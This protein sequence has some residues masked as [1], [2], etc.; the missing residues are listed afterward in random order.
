MNTNPVPLS[1]RM[2]AGYGAADFGMA[3]VEVML[4][5]FLLEFYTRA[6]GLQSSL[7][8]YALA[9]A[10]AWD[11][12]TDPLMGA[13]SDRTHTRWGMRRPYMAAGGILF[14]VS[15]PVLF[16][17]PALETQAGKFAYLLGAYLLLNTSYTI[18]SVPYTALAGEM[19]SDRNDRAELFGWRLL[20]RNGGF[21]I[22]ALLPG[23]L[24]DAA[25]PA[26]AAAALRDSRGAT[27]WIL[28]GAVLATAWI[29]T[30]AVRRHDTPVR[31]GRREGGAL[32]PRWFLH[33]ARRVLGNPLFLP[34]IIAFVIA[35]SGRT[36][37]AS[38]GI[39]YY[40]IRLGLGERDI[41]LIL[42]VFILLVSASVPMWLAIARRTG[43]KPAAFTGALA[44][45][46]MTAVTYPLLPP[47]EIAP[48][49]V[50]ACGIGGL[51]AG[52][53]IL[54]EALVADA[55]DYDE[56]K[57]GKHREGLY[58]GVWT[59]ATKLARALG[60]ALTGVMLDAIGLDPAAAAHPPEAGWRIALLFGPGV[61]L[62]FVIAA[63]V[64]LALPYSEARQ[65]RIQALLRRRAGRHP[66]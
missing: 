29:S 27:A 48:V 28:A 52:A 16:W 36:I 24:Y 41:A 45:G 4:Q 66:L 61:G 46:A 8:G 26:G 64:F 59:M 1:R 21:L 54:F 53:V 51:A 25:E 44:L 22:G 37:N 34:L 12:V 14:A 63:L 13:V 5:L 2:K 32:D 3:G 15:V 6:V 50:F 30:I 9:I 43:K 10:V 18:L 40:K 57:T 20:A 33:E 35:Q 17:P 49:L 58:Y 19:T 65:D 11:A 56:L 38:L 39:Y 60:L 42:G 7:A 62:W 31:A 23:L 55:V 47:G